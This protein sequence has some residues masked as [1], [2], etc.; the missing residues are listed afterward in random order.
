MAERERTVN[1]SDGWEDDISVK[2]LESHGFL[3]GVSGGSR[4]RW[5]SGTEASVALPRAHASGGNGC[6]Q[7]LKGG[8]KY[9]C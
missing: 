2:V 9:I 8:G 6:V 4:Y 1:R 3:Q 5:T 7:K